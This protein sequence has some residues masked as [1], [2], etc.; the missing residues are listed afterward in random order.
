[1]RAMNTD[2]QDEKGKNAIPQREIL[3][4]RSLPARQSLLNSLTLTLL[5]I[6][7]A[8]CN[9]QTKPTTNDSLK[10]FKE[11]VYCDTCAFVKIVN[12]TLYLSG[13]KEVTRNDT[14]KI[15]MLMTDTSE[16]NGTTLNGNGIVF[17][18]IGYEVR[19]G[20]FICCDPKNKN[21]SSYYWV[22]THVAY[23]NGDKKQLP[24]NIIVWQSKEF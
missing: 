10:R 20:Q 17:W 18:Q 19:T 7:P 24:K 13:R 9:G 4:I 6:F 12:D 14:V 15:I 11:V 3:I 5:F 1:M 22:Y 21:N 23:I 16:Y 8:L 2:E